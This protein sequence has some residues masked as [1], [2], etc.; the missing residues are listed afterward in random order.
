MRDEDQQETGKESG[1]INH[2]QQDIIPTL[3]S[4]MPRQLLYTSPGLQ[5]RNLYVIITL[6]SKQTDDVK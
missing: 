6:N 3:F 4:D 2:C 1:S 5:L